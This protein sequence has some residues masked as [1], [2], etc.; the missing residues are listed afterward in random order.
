MVAEVWYGDEPHRSF[1]TETT[2]CDFDTPAQTVSSLIPL[3]RGRRMAVQRRQQL[4]AVLVL[5]LGTFSRHEEALRPDAVLQL[6][7]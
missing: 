3:L 7:I 4:V 6:E 1:C 5:W 2:Y